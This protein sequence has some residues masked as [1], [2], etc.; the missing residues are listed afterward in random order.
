M[1]L[2]TQSLDSG[3]P[4]ALDVIREVRSAFRMD[5][6]VPHLT[7]CGLR[8]RRDDFILLVPCRMLRAHHHL[9]VAGCSDMDFPRDMIDDLMSTSGDVIVHVLPHLVAIQDMDELGTTTDANELLL[10]PDAFPIRIFLTLITR[11]MGMHSS[12]FVLII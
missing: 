12:V 7:V 3:I 6:L 2:V 8:C 1:S 10:E 4:Q 9:M 5:G 11:G